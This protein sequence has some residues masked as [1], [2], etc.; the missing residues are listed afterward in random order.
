[1]NQYNRIVEYRYSF[2]ITTNKYAHFS[3]NTGAKECYMFV[4]TMRLKPFFSGE[5]S[6]AKCLAK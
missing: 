3:S 4:D 1:M 2:W 5:T 6:I